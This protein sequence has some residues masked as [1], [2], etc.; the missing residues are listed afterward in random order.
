MG[1]ALKCICK[2]ETQNIICS[3]FGLSKLY[4]ISYLIFDKSLGNISFKKSASSKLSSASPFLIVL[5]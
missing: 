3:N 4:P 5:F 2:Y 1:N